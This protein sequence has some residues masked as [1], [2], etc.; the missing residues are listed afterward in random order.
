MLHPLN[1]EHNFVPWHILRNIV[2]NIVPSPALNDAYIRHVIC[3]KYKA[4]SPDLR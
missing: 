1:T 2:Q 4:H 3:P